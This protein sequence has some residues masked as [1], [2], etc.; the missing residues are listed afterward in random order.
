MD[1]IGLWVGFNAFVLAMLAIDLGVFHRKAHVVSVKEAAIWSVVW[2]ALALGFGAGVSHFIGKEEGLEFFA[3]YLIEKALSVDNIFVFV[4]IFSYFRVEP[5][6]QHRVLYWG[7]LGALLMRG[8]MIGLGAYL[9][10]RFAWILY[11]FGAFLVWTGFRMARQHEP[12]VDPASN[13]MLR[14]VRRTLPLAQQDHGAQL[15]AREPVGDSGHHHL[16]V[17]PLFVVLVLVETTDLVFAVDSIPA[18][19]A[20]TQEPF[21]VYSS[22]VFAILGLRSLY[23]VLN[24]VID[25]FRYLKLGLSTVLIFV[26]VKMLL[27]DAYKIPIG[28]SLVVIALIVAASILMSQLIRPKDLTSVGETQVAEAEVEVETA[29][30]S[31]EDAPA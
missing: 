28:V 3:G 29:S 22:N 19:F 12:P 31:Q 23:F 18:I 13:P 1:Q 21:L 24:G 15:I 25:R 8:T 7:I 16:V 30:S 9:V 10:H 6:N 5:K 2:V 26:G 14:L 20:V 27:A 17:T 4:L 11:F